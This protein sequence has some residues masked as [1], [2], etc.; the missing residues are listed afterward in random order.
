MG[1]RKPATAEPTALAA[2]YPATAADGTAAGTA[3][4]SPAGGDAPT[5]TRGSL[6]SNHWLEER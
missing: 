6:E 3:A 1:S 5:I 4:T 2:R